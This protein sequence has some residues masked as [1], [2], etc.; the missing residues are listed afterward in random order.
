MREI[1]VQR[2]VSPRGIP[3]AVTLRR[4]ARA[5]LNGRKYEIT[6][7]I[8]DEA[9]SRALN[10]KFRGKDKP[11]NVLSFP[12]EG[13]SPVSG[14]PSLIRGDVVICA[15]VVNRESREQNKTTAA[16]WAHMVV[17]GVLHLLGYDHI[18]GGEARVME[19]RERAILARLSFPD[20][21]AV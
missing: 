17:H 13:A 7:R 20:P 11:T 16:H 3:S 19:N 12:Y 2:C 8:V 18:K 10:R 1:V 15:P 5:A 9:E 21:Y 4:Y 14:L 6:L